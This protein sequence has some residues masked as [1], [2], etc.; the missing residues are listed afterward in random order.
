[1]KL[2]VKHWLSIRRVE[3]F[4][5][6]L[7]NPGRAAL[8]WFGVACLARIRHLLVPDAIHLADMVE[9]YAE[10]R[11]DRPTILEAYKAFVQVHYTPRIVRSQDD[12]CD[13]DIGEFDSYGS[14][15]VAFAAGLVVGDLID[16]D[17]D[18][19]DST[20]EMFWVV[21][22][23]AETC[24]HAVMATIPDLP[25]QHEEL[26]AELEP[27]RAA[28]LGLPP[29]QLRQ[30]RRTPELDREL[31][32]IYQELLEANGRRQERREQ[33]WETEELEQCNLAREVIRPPF[34]TS[35]APSC[36]TSTVLA[37]ANEIYEGRAFDRMPTLA[38]VL[39]HAG[40][41][42]ANVLD[43]CLS[44]APHERGCWVIALILGKE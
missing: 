24:R 18:R 42:D 1:M 33:T 44:L 8:V 40:C 25:W 29:C 37:L 35:L 23:M 31:H 41:K 15:A 13:I 39:Q 28:L 43:H 17:D 2:S 3:D 10:G 5:P 6:V 21:Q 22:G 26:P 19:F 4:R 27:F 32:A 11:L 9:A 38:E 30:L 34:V 12:T 20:R 7:G 14:E 36:R 16:P